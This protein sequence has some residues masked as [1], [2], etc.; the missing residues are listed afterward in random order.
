MFDMTI[1]AFAR[2]IQNSLSPWA[3]WALRYSPE[4]NIVTEI[5][6]NPEIISKH[7]PEFLNAEN[8]TPSFILGLYNRTAFR[9]TSGRGKARTATAIVDNNN[10]TVYLVEGLYGEIELSITVSSRS[11]DLIEQFEFMYYQKI[12]QYAQLSYIMQFIKD[13]EKV[14]AYYEVECGDLEEFTQVE[15]GTAGS[16]WAVTFTAKLK[17]EFFAYSITPHSKV[18]RQYA[19]LKLVHNLDED[20]VLNTIGDYVI[21][22]DMVTGEISLVEAP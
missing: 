10:Q 8:P 18:L 21:E 2:L 17:G 14:P 11:R 20:T 22:K 19:S 4:K 7:S 5:R 15:G 13:G 1:Q 16:L 12:K 6:K 3:E 9:Q